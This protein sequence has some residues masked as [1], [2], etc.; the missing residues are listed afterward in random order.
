MFQVG[1]TYGHKTITG[2]LA[3]QALRVSQQRVGESL[4]R[5][6]PTFAL[7][8]TNLELLANPPVEAHHW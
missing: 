5:M 1:P 8:A 2:L 4:R 3:S 6:N 7:V